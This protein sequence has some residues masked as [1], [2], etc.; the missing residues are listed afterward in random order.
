MV[1]RVSGTLLRYTDYRRDIDLDATT[2]GGAIDALIEAY[3]ALKAILFGRD[4]RLRATH[5]IFLNGEQLTAS[6]WTDT[7]A[8]NDELDIATA[9]A[10]G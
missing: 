7:V 1:V 6:A 9:V 4:G 8:A 3:P 5:R 2:V 10:G